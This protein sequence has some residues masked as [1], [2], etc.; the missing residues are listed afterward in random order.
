VSGQ[1]HAPAALTSGKGPRYLPYRSLDGP[2][3]GSGR[4]EEEKILLPHINR[5]QN[6]RG[7][8][9][10]ESSSKI[11]V[12]GAESSFKAHVFVL[13]GVYLFRIQCN[14]FLTGKCNTGMAE[15]SA[16]RPV[17]V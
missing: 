2:Q 11:M 6:A 17:R 13:E 4:Y 12:A 15:R 10:E 14:S 8:S 16:P 7:A 5:I 1:L 3:S 9:T